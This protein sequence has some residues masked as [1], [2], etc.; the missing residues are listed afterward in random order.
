MFWKVTGIYFLELGHHLK[1]KK[2]KKITFYVQHLLYIR[3][4]VFD[5]LINPAYINEYFRD[6][7]TE[8]KKQL[9][10]LGLC[11][12]GGS[13]NIDKTLLWSAHLSLDSFWRSLISGEVLIH[14]GNNNN[15]I[16]SINI[17]WSMLKIYILFLLLFLFCKIK[18]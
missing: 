3:N 6:V 8:K 9:Y 12:F 15:N 16:N 10:I 4:N 1:K 14:L 5:M 13:H 18:Q 17:W 7:T 11:N 2:K